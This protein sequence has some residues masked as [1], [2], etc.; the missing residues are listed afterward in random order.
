MK[1]LN[2]DI[3]DIGFIKRPISLLLRKK[4]MLFLS[5]FV[6][7][8]I[9]SL[10]VFLLPIKYTYQLTLSP[11]EMNLFDEVSKE[12]SF[13]EISGF[14]FGDSSPLIFQKFKL[15]L[16]SYRI[17]EIISKD[18]GILIFNNNLDKSVEDVYDH[19]QKEIVVR[20]FGGSGSKFINVSY[21][22]KDPVLS[23][24]ILNY[25]YGKADF[26]IK[27]SQKVSSSKKLKYLYEKLETTKSTFTRSSLASIIAKEE[28]ILAMAD[29]DSQ[30]ASE[31]I[32]YN[33]F[34]DS[35]IISRLIKST[36]Y[37]LLSYLIFL[38]ICLIFIQRKNRK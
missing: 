26:L 12:S 16:R 6:L 29:L 37:T 14:S 21:T 13:G 35:E 31:V 2:Q 3:I 7:F 11:N 34:D 32:D 10:S 17:A 22:S 4:K 23:E 15:L 25:V 30:F 28:A 19:L 9:S 36:F 38:I 20:N 33:Y 27:N 8:F 24:T 1:D 18:D 5:F